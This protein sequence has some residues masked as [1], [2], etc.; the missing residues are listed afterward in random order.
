MAET[1]S[2]KKTRGAGKRKLKT[3]MK[4]KSLFFGDDTLTQ[5]RFIHSETRRSTYEAQRFSRCSASKIQ[6]NCEWIENND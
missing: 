6:S 5:C 2:T 3:D 1:R 4:K